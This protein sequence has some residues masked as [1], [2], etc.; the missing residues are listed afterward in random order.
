ML[1]VAAE[2][3]VAR[4]DGVAEIR[5]DVVFG[6]VVG[7]LQHVDFERAAGQAARRLQAVE[8]LIAARIA[9]QQHRL[10]AEA[11]CPFSST[12]SVSDAR[13]GGV[14]LLGLP[15]DFRLEP[16]RQEQ[17]ADVAGCSAS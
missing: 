15:N 14:T 4:D 3:V 1:A 2:D 13:F 12:S 8:D 6:A 7:H 9:C 11:P 16:H 5:V 10:M 17:P